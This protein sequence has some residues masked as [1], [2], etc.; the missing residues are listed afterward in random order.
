M[1]ST[2]STACLAPAATSCP[3]GS[4]ISAGECLSC[5][6]NTFSAGGSATSCTAC[7]SGLSSG[8]GAAACYAIGGGG[9]VDTG[10][11]LTA[12]LTGCT[13]TGSTFSVGGNGCSSITVGSTTVRVKW[14]ACTG[15]ATTF[16][17]YAGTDTKC[18]TS[19]GSSVTLSPSNWVAGNPD[20]PGVYLYYG[21]GTSCVVGGS[22]LNGVVFSGTC[23]AAATS[24]PANKYLSGAACV[25]CPT[26]ATSPAGSTSLSS[27]ACAANSYR[28]GSVCN[29]CASGS[30]APAGSTSST[31][32]VA[33]ATA[34]PA[35]QYLLGTSCQRCPSG[36]TSLAG[37]TSSNACSVSTACASLTTQATVVAVPATGS[38]V[39]NA[40]A[41]EGSSTSTLT[42]QFVGAGGACGVLS[43]VCTQ[44]LCAG[45][46][47]LVGL[48]SLSS[49][50]NV[51]VFGCPQGVTTGTVVYLPVGLPST[52]LDIVRAGG[53][54]AA[55]STST[56]GASAA[57][58]ASAL[59]LQLK[60]F[61]CSTD[62]CNSVTSAAVTACAT[63]SAVVTTCP[64]NQY[65]SS[66][67]C[68]SCPSGTSS[69]SGSTSSSACIAVVQFAYS[70]NNVPASLISS[71]AA[72]N[73]LASTISATLLTNTGGSGSTAVVTLF[74]IADAAGATIW[75]TSRLLAGAENARALQTASTTSLT[76]TFTATG[77]GVSS[78]FVTNNAPGLI[79]T[80]V[81]A[82]APSA[83]LASTSPFIL[84]SSATS[85][86]CAATRPS[87]AATSP[88]GASSTSSTGAIIGGVVG[89]VC[90]ILFGAGLARCCCRPLQV[91]PAE[92]KHA[93]ANPNITYIQQPAPI[94]MQQGA[95]VYMNQPAPVYAQQQPSFIVREVKQ[96]P[97][98]ATV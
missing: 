80:V 34:C 58:T 67:S 11:A 9:Y 8:V 60:V 5:S 93:D 53:I 32:C 37:S 85:S 4:Y 62:N 6:A 96:D 41:L 7:A 3:A 24:C 76:L 49:T 55:K 81:A 15:G 14:S 78:S 30:A 13:S 57:F 44:A 84:C 28:S 74:S 79:T 90:L 71:P 72:I 10:I 45:T 94:Y 75:P 82:A 56:N 89:G 98:G 1:G 2:S 59:A 88:A 51:A 92:H 97:Q 31:A 38:L 16:K 39:C 83:T 77:S 70:V 91:T 48:G 54:I 12:Q 21:Y 35:G 66:G 33:T 17:Y 52:V 25:S 65:L 50:P 36:Y 68:A 22:W 26:G 61:T 40:I 64:A 42:S 20:A 29:L 47:C 27:C 19:V 95:P 69:P 46:N 87:A 86:S 18:D 43:G 73:S 63:G 23:A